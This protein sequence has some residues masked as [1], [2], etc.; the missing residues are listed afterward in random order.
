MID[1]EEVNL[2]LRE[3]AQE[4]GRTG[5]FAAKTW[6]E[7]TTHIK[8]PF[9]VYKFESQCAVTCLDGHVKAFDLFGLVHGRNVPLYVEVKTYTSAGDQAKAF[10][11]FLAI[12]YSATAHEKKRTGDWNAEFMWV[13]THPFSVTDWSRL[14]TREHIKSALENDGGN[15]LNGEAIDEGLLTEMTSRI[16]LLVL[17]A[18]QHELVLSA[19]ELSQVEAVLNRE[20]KS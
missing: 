11:N 19:A 5:V 3:R 20:G 15:I 17:N 6:L 14:T 4:T 12:A 9:D 18:R 8:L 10:D 2:A 7:S 16:W 13:T 1:H